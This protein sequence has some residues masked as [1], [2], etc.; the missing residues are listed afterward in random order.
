[1]YRSLFYL[2]LGVK[3]DERAFLFRHGRFERVLGPGRHAIFDPARAC[4]IETFKVV[5]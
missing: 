4:S 3:D 5:R 2:L 1:M